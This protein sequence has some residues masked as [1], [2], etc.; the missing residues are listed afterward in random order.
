MHRYI[1][2]IRPSLTYQQALG[3]MIR[4]VDAAHFV[5][6]YRYKTGASFE[7]WRGP[8]PLKFLPGLKAEVSAPKI[9]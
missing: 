9:R 6:S 4:Q 7:L 3:E 1:E 2:R 5:K 8:K